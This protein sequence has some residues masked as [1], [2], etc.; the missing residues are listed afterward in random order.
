MDIQRIAAFAEAGLGGNPA[1]VVIGDTLPSR[2]DMQR[3]A[4]EVGYSE[5]AFA[6]PAPGGWTVR[7]FAPEGEV[8]FC[9][10]ATIALGCALGQR[11]GPGRY[12]LALS[13][14]DISVEVAE[15]VAGWR[16][17]LTSPPTWS[18]AMPR[19][20]VVALLALFDWDAEV[21]DAGLRPHLA[22]GGVT[23]GVLALHDRAV[24]AAMDYDFE[25]MRALMLAE[26]L[27]TISLLFCESPLVFVARNA[28]ASGGVVEDPATGAAAAA[29]GGLLVDLDWPGLQGGGRFVIR[30][31]EDMGAPS[32][33]EVEVSGHKGAPV[34]VS[35]G[36][37][38]L[39]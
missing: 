37:L 5:T 18:R 19:G 16:A 7:Y 38:D 25:G 24:L 1:G 34:R 6:A 11:F 35:G 39:R 26:G 9:G 28:F 3:V 10:H 14:A 27:T 20:M 29:L 15:G 30:Q 23:H 4:R 31:G 17:T 22:H 32:R 13:G 33:I 2:D 12:G 21:L 36:S 8:A